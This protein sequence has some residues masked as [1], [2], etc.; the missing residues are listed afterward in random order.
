MALGTTY[1][2]LFGNLGGHVVSSRAATTGFQVGLIDS[3]GNRAWTPLGKLEA[4]LCGGLRYV[5][6]LEYDQFL[7]H[8]RIY[9]PVT[10]Y[11]HR[12]ELAGPAIDGDCLLREESDVVV[13][14]SKRMQV[15]QAFQ[16]Y[17][18]KWFRGTTVSNGEDLGSGSRCCGQFGLHWSNCALIWGLWTT[19]N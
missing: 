1:F 10:F 8:L 14:G 16:S 9:G 3:R 5:D 2:W 6:L 11:G 17:R 18:P 13:D 12:V 15:F 4:T 7:V 19:R